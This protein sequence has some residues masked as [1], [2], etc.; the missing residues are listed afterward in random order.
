VRALAAA[1][2][3]MRRALRRGSTAALAALIAAGAVASATPDPLDAAVQEL[4][5]AAGTQ[6]LLLLGEKHGTREIPQLVARLVAA[7]AAES[8][9]LLALEIHRPEQA[10]LTAYLH[11]DGGAAS[12]AALRAGAFWQV[13][14]DQHDGRR[15]LDMLELIEQLRRLRGQGAQLDLLAYDHDP[16]SPR[17]S[18]GREAE[19]A[20]A[21]RAAYAA[22][23]HGRLLVLTGNAHAQL[24]RPRS[25]PPA[26]PPPMAAQLHDLDPFTVDIAASDGAFWGCI[27]RR[28]EARAERMPPHSGGPQAPGPDRRYHH[29]LLLPRFS[30]ARLLGAGPEAPRGAE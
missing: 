22:L 30:V 27:E 15:S 16:A 29:R 2:D 6:R 13:T 20:A 18:G 11:S 26:L 4:R 24:Q 21:V 19:L 3:R 25:A 28:C 10:A 7:Y 1:V 5:A 9:L 17:G 14:D 8:P 12:R 23:P